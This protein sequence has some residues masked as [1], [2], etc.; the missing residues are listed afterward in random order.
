MVEPLRKVILQRH[1]GLKTIDDVAQCLSLSTVD[2][3]EA[4][5][6]DCADVDG[7]MPK[8]YRIGHRH[9]WCLWCAFGAFGRRHF[10]SDIEWV[11]WEKTG[12]M[13]YGVH[14]PYEIGFGFGRKD[15]RYGIQVARLLLR[16][17]C[18]VLSPRLVNCPAMPEPHSDMHF[19][20]YA[21]R[22]NAIDGNDTMDIISVL[23]Q[24]VR[25][26]ELERYVASFAEHISATVDKFSNY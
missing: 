11:D 10:A 25:K 21:L 3:G 13:Q 18:T 2:M 16:S 6:S 12:H 24:T 17:I 19:F 4:L 14:M 26:A 5:P 1:P 9:G 22:R 15:P 8:T 20:D 23:P 7:V